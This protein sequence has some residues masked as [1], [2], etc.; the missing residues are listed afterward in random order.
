M[1]IRTGYVHEAEAKRR[2]GD[3]QFYRLLQDLECRLQELGERSDF[4]VPAEPTF[5]VETLTSA[6]MYVASLEDAKEGLL[7]EVA[8]DLIECDK[9]RRR[10]KLFRQLTGIKD[11][12]HSE[13]SSSDISRGRILNW[14]CDQGYQSLGV[15]TLSVQAALDRDPNMTSAGRTVLREILNIPGLRE[16][17][18]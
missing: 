2:K 3:R 13:L 10:L 7:L 15:D 18:Q 12:H 4:G 17:Q 9:E 1:M 14:L 11:L 6:I 8:H 16:W 5:A